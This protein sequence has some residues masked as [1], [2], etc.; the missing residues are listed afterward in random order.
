MLL[1]VVGLVVALLNI[2]SIARIQINKALDRYLVAGGEVEK[3]DIRLTKGSIALRKLTLHPPPN[4][5]EHP[6]LAWDELIVDIAPFS[7]FSGKIVVE[8]IGMKGLA[9]TVVRDKNGDLNILQMMPPDAT[10]PPS[11]NNQSEPDPPWIP[12]IHINATMVEDLSLLL[13]DQMTGEQWSA[14]LHLDLKV[15]GLQLN[16]IMAQDIHAG[17]VDMSVTEIKFDQLPGFGRDPM[18]AAGAFQLTTGGFDLNTSEVSLSKVSLDTLSVSVERNVDREVNLIKLAESWLPVSAEG[19][20]NKQGSSLPTTDPSGSGF[21]LPTVVVDN[22][23]LKTISA[24]LL[25]SMEGQLWR[26]G[27]DGLDIRVTGVEVGD[28]AEQ[29]IALA[30]LDLNLKGMAVDQPPGFSETPLLSMGSFKLASQG[31]DLGASRASISDVILDG[32]SISVERNASDEV[33]LLNLKEAW[34]PASVEAS[35]DKLDSSVSTTDASGSGFELPTVV[36]DNIELKSISAQLLAS[37]EDQL[38]RAGFD[39]L[40]IRVTGVEVGDPTEQAVSLASFDLDLKG[41][42]VDQPPGFDTEKLFSLEQFTIISEKPDKTKKEL[43]IKQVSLTGLTSYVIMHADGISNLQVLNKALLGKSEEPEA[44]REEPTTDRKAPSPAPDLQPVLFEQ[45]SL[46]GGPVT[47]RDEFFAEETLVASLD[48]I[49]LE[50]TDLRLFNKEEGVDPA[51]AEMSFELAQ[52]GELPTAYFGALVDV[53]P[54]GYG[55]PMVNSQVRLVGLKLDSLGSLVPKA[56]RTA[57]G[58]SGLDGALALALDAEAI[59]LNAAVLTDHGIKYKGLKVKGPLEAPV[60]EPGPIMTGVLSRVSEG[61]VNLGK[62]GLKSGVNIA[63]GGVEMVKELGSGTVE[64]GKNLGKSLFGATAGIVTLDK[65]KVKEGASG[66]TKGTVDIT[67]G[68]VKGSG[69]AAGG[70]LKSSASE[71]KGQDRVD[72]WEEGIPTRYQSTMQHA[73]TVLAEMP[74]PPVT[75]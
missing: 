45:I 75:K 9:L 4:F 20:G 32:L 23:E 11:T 40:D 56:T 30:S 41:I 39:G 24:Q 19:G 58:A 46:D 65:D 62:G 18:M 31:I 35:G 69:Q 3:V 17:P 71:L 28:L 60:V 22:I 52:P 50:A 44:S 29:A 48:N 37:I 33:N 64:V 27:F 10:G 34:L 70:S 53:G 73:K 72:A 21:K 8:Q 59:N 43:V 74:Y 51:S 5:G 16:D 7:I 54:I 68:S 63:E 57:L 47:Y 6:P 26:A 12:V 36:V 15:V 55:V 61:L 66:T 67:K 13:L 42:A 2:D 49:H 25:D 14:G 38:W 1:A